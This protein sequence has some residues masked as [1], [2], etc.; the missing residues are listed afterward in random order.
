MVGKDVMIMR[1]ICRV[2]SGRN[3]HISVTNNYYRRGFLCSTPHNTLLCIKSRIR[4]LVR[5]PREQAHGR[6]APRP[7]AT[8][9]PHPSDRR[10]V[11]PGA[12]H[13]VTIVDRQTPFPRN[14]FKPSATPCD[15]SSLPESPHPRQ[16]PLPDQN[17]YAKGGSLL[18]SANG[19]ILVS[20]EAPAEH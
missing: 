1:S 11:P 17:R 2:C 15:D 18:V 20:A 8:P 13:I 9:L 16:I 10:A 14:P 5:L 7:P 12:R 4:R 19:S 3:G 6:G